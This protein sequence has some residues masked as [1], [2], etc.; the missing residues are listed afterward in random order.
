MVLQTMGAGMLIPILPELAEDRLGL[1]G[2]Q[3][4]LLLLAGGALTILGLIP[5]GRLSDK[6]GG[7]KWFLVLG[8]CC[9]RRGTLP[10]RA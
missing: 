5:L 2:K 6:L 4:S 9:I 7:K 1:N 10:A 3:Y 8:F